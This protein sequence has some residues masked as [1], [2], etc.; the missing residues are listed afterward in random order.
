MEVKKSLI[1]VGISS[2]LMAGTWATATAK[3]A[4]EEDSVYRWGRWAVLAPA[5]GVEEVI[6][7]AP[8]GT[9][10]LGRCESDA[11]CPS[12]I[13]VEPVAVSPCE[14]GAPCGFARI[15]YRT[16]G[17]SQAF[18]RYVGL[19]DLSLVDGSDT[20]DESSVGYIIA[21]PSA[22]N[23]EAVNLNSGTLPVLVNYNDFRSTARDTPATISGR[24][25]RNDAGDV[26][27]VQGPWRQIGPEGAYAHSGEYVWGITATAGQMSALFDKLGG[28]LGGDILAAYTGPTAT[29]GLI[30][31]DFNFSQSTWSGTIQGTVLDFNAGGTIVN[32]G[33]VSNP[34]QFSSND[35]SNI[36]SGDL[37]GGFVNAGNNAIGGYEVSTTGGLRDADVFNA[38]LQGPSLQPSAR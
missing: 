6:A 20:E 26:A 9:D 38:A 13:V 29:G 34:G 12:I 27:V 2:V 24:F 4:E 10:E 31:L 1:A 11:N 7:F 14:A 25:I 28:G 22:P 36:A 33:F 16:R 18:D 23:G 17:S 35:G 3:T 8:A 30:N 32:S 37:Q 19:I 15:D 21:G 5:A